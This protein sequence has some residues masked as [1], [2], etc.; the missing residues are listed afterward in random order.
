M[1]TP[2]ALG[3]VFALAL[4]A[5]ASAPLHAQQLVLAQND[6]L[7]YSNSAVG[8]PASVLGFRFT[9]P[10]AM[11]LDAAQVFTGNQPP[12]SHTL[13]IRTRNATTG[14]PDQLVGQ[15]GTWMTVH[16][17]CWQ[18]ARFAQPAVLSANT[19]YFLVWRVTGMFHQHSTSNANDPS[20]TQSEIRVSDGST[21][22][23]VTTGPAKF[24]LF[25]P[26]TAGTTLAYG[27]GKTGTYGVPQIGLSGW[28]AI[29]SPIDVWLD[30]AVRAQPTFLV[31]GW[32]IPGGLSFPVGDLFVTGEVVLP[33]QPWL[34]T[35]PL[36]GAL[37]YTFQVP[38]T[39]VASGLPLSFQFG[40]IDPTATLG[41]AH[42]GAVT[43]VLQ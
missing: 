42:T 9:A 25:A 29:G 14:L 28:P 32:P 18:G 20:Q 2:P 4:I 24:R 34:H 33:V 19:D 23:A 41:F 5:T 11:V 21:W 15:P 16:A 30:S 13:E 39:P 40:M 3:F 6:N 10:T 43:A 12:A 38:N 36:C 26:Y 22:H 27:N 8:W 17:R 7:S 1:R 37:S 31:V 35:S